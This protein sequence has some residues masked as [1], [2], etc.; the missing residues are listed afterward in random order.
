MTAPTPE[1][2]A[3]ALACVAADEFLT[4]CPPPDARW[5][6]DTALRPVLVAI[7]TALA[8]QAFAAARRCVITGNP[9]GT[10]TW[11]AGYVC[12]CEP[13]LFYMTIY[14]AGQAAERARII[15]LVCG[16]TD[17]RCVLDN[18]RLWAMC[19]AQRLIPWIPEAELTA[20]LHAGEGQP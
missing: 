7:L 3:A 12:P 14:A 1:W 6:V 16:R 9:L 2:S 5:Y 11:A 20:A 15:R 10:D 19:F 18:G 17:G 13:C 8:E 4:A